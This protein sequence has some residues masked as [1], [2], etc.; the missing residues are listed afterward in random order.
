MVSWFR[1]LLLFVTAALSGAL[2]PA[3]AQ[4]AASPVTF[5]KDVAPILFSQ[6]VTCHRPGG[7]AGSTLLTF[8]DARRRARQIAAVTASRTMPPWKPEPGFGEFAGDRRLTGKQIETFQR[9]IEGGLVEGAP[10]DLPRQPDRC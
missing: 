4:P 6:C 2:S 10:A 7:S 8:D 1:V 9:W 3:V 5:N